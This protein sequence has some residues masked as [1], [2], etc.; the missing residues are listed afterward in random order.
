MC[1]FSPIIRV[2]FKN[3]WGI[4]SD[5]THQRQSSYKTSKV[6]ISI[7]NAYKNLP[8][9]MS[10]HNRLSL[11]HKRTWGGAFLTCWRSLC[12]CRA[13]RAMPSHDQKINL[14]GFPM[15]SSSSKTEDSWATLHS[16]HIYFIQGI[17]VVAKIFSTGN[18]GLMVCT[19]SFFSQELL[20]DNN[21]ALFSPSVYAKR[22]LPWRATSIQHIS[23]DSQRTTSSPF[24]ASSPTWN[25]RQN[26]REPLSR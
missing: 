8:P 16:S 4:Y 9:S 24:L 19:Y 18:E 12:R 13:D 15:N 7:E 17:M 14:T 21:N 11:G 6:L 3:F 22:G 25:P 26:C 2:S 23:G 5:I 10:F 20:P 1:S